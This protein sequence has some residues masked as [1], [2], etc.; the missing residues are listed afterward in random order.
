MRRPWP[1]VGITIEELNVVCYQQQKRGRMDLSIPGSAKL[2]IARRLGCRPEHTLRLRKLPLQDQ[3]S[4]PDAIHLDMPQVIP[5]RLSGPAVL[6][7][8]AAVPVN[9]PLKSQIAAPFIDFG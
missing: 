4:Q 5:L 1:D 8:R 6:V 3:P 7:L 9:R 2:S